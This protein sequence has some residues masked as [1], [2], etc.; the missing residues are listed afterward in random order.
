MSLDFTW[1]T[2]ARCPRHS[3][4]CSVILIVKCHDIMR[5]LLFFS[6]TQAFRSPEPIYKIFL[7]LAEQYGR[8][9]SLKLGSF[10][11]IVL[12]DVDDIRG[13]YIKQPIDFAGRPNLYSSKYW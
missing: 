5:E 10:W 8:I 1:L 13:A 3:A 12:N 2:K 9:F 7:Q 11:V 4:I 6:L